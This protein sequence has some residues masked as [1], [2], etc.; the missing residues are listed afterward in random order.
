M[1]LKSLDIRLLPGLDSPLSVSFDPNA[2]NVVTGPNASG[3][4]SLI[5]AVRAVLYPDQIDSFCHIVAEFESDGKTLSCE[6]RGSHSSW[7]HDGAPDARPDLPGAESLG[8]YLISSEDLAALGS[9]EAHIAAELRTMLAGGYD[10]DA[11]TS[12]GLLA[13]R[14]RPQKLAGELAQINREVA[15]KETEY[16][17]LDEELAD[18]D[19]LNA[20]LADSAEAA[21]GL[22]ACE[23]AMAL[24]EAFARRSAIETTLIDDFPGGMDRLRGDELERIEQVDDQIARREKDLQVT[25]SGLRQTRERLAK[26]GSVDPDTL[27]ALQSELSGQRDRLVELERRIEQQTEAVE[28]HETSLKRAARRLGSERPEMVDKLDQQALEEL[29]KRVD[30][31]QI[32]RE[33]IRNLTAELARTHVSKNQTGRSQDDLRAARHALLRWLDGANLSPL[34]GVLWGG[35]GGAA[36]IAAW[37]LLGV[38]E[39]G[40]SP[41]LL[42]LILLGVG[43]P[44][45]LLVNFANRWRDLQRAQHDFIETDIEQPLGWTEDEVQSRLERLE[46]ELESATRHEISQARAAEVRDQLNAQRTNLDSARKRLREFAD[47]IGVS[48]DDRLETGFQLWCRHLHDWQLEHQKCESARQQLDQLKNRY[49]NLQ[50]ETREMLARHGMPDQSEVDSRQVAG[51]INQL[52]PRMRRNAELHNEAQGHERRIDELQADIE[53]LQ[54]SRERIFEQA[55]IDSQDLLTLTQRIDQF[56]SWR[57]LEQEQ[58]DCSMEISRLESRLSAEGE[59]LRQAREQQHEQLGKRHEELSASAERRDRLNRR[60]AEI[61]TRHEELLGRRELETLTDQLETTRQALDE[62]LDRHLL[63]TAGQVLIDNVRSTHESDNEPTALATAGQWF[64][65]FTRHRYRLLFE[66]DGFLAHD[67]HQNRRCGLTELSTGTRVQLLL[68]VRLAWIAQAEQHHESLPVFMD[69]V[70]TTTD[71]DRYQA[72]VESVQEIAANGRQMFY[73]TAQTDDARAWTEW[74]SEG[75]EPHTIDMAEVRRGAVEP[76]QYSMP[77]GEPVGHRV[78]NPDGMDA[79]EWAE[80]AAVDPVNPWLGSGALHAFHL[81]HDRLDLA[82][83]LMKLDLVRHGEIESFL[84]SPQSNDRIDDNDRDLLETRLAAARLI[85]EDWCKRHNRP[86]TESDLHATDL[87][88]TPFMERVTELAREV[89]GDPRALIDGLRDGKVA[90]FRSDTTDQLEQWFMQHGFFNAELDRERATAVSI[91]ERTGLEPDEVTRLRD[92]IEGAVYKFRP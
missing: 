14:S 46:L 69:E 32:L 87:I 9:T 42:L 66:G 25:R 37:R 30:R 83:H 52:V 26:T 39:V 81:L 68:A 16:A 56:E 7:T 89:E 47:N 55:G 3:K 41:E 88:S 79:L 78:P 53:Q 62:E 63:A 82:A 74:V 76:L 35:L 92:W 31:V 34:E 43:I 71:P 70:L 22:R 36:M 21:A 4:S 6:R 90:R 65:R 61:Q 27:E 58:R 91:A 54:K 72:V 44:L 73:L 5:R 29:E 60:I 86:V 2:V 49:R 11:L 38:Q 64:E 67:T 33:Q 51:L 12:E 8:A 40:L 59:L 48:S 85:L 50:G 18:L 84:A 1:K 15:D 23:D 19:R 45:G 20:E 13:P 17:R 28:R 75:P 10:L 57:Q 24:A 80:A 77:I